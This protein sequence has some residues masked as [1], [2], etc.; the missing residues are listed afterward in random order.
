M[1]VIHSKDWAA[2]EGG[3]TVLAELPPRVPP[4]GDDHTQAPDDLELAVLFNADHGDRID[5]DHLPADLGRRDRQRVAQ[6]LAVVRDGR[7]RTGADYF[8]AAMICQHG[9]QIE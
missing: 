5:E 7:L 2:T 3:S 4:P 8:R 1:G 6:M 9:P